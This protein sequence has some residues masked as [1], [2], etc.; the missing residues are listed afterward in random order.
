MIGC[1]Y[2]LA[3]LRPA[4][5]QQEHAD[6]QV[7]AEKVQRAFGKVTARTK[8]LGDIVKRLPVRLQSHEIS[9][10]LDPLGAVKI[11][12]Q[13]VSTGDF[14]VA[15]S[16]HRRWSCEVEA[17]CKIRVAIETQK[18]LGLGFHP[19]DCDERANFV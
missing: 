10:R 5:I 8:D 6:R 18:R 13:P 4:L 7:E 9:D 15:R 3:D 11:A 14:Q 1:L 2:G 17:L 12:Y 19:F 16:G